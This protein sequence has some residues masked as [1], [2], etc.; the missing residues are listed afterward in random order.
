MLYEIE[1]RL[2]EAGVLKF[3]THRQ[4]VFYMHEDLPFHNIH[5]DQHGKIDYRKISPPVISSVATNT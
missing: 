1:A 2:I 4:H 3:L 5:F